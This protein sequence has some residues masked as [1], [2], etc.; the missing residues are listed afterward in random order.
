V[1]SP[2]DEVSSR[3]D[4]IADDDGSSFGDSTSDTLSSG[5]EDGTVGQL[6][7]ATLEAIQV[8]VLRSQQKRRQIIS[9]VCKL[10]MSHYG[11]YLN[12]SPYRVPPLSGYE[13]T[14]R[15]LGSRRQC[16]NMFRMHRDVFDSL[17]NILLERYGLKPTRKI[18]STEALA[19]FYGCVVG[20]SP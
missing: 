5:S 20:N 17:H 7:V 8:H 1:D 10:G 15:T 18:T 11:K 12:K 6:Q 4:S 19:I 3:G 2:I 14:I 13:W 9:V 16:Y